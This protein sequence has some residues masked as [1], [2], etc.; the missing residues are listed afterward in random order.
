MY[1]WYCSRDNVSCHVDLSVITNKH[2]LGNKY[3]G[4][5]RV[6]HSVECSTTVVFM[7]QFCGTVITDAFAA[8]PLPRVLAAFV[9]SHLS[10][11]FSEEIDAVL[12]Q[13]SIVVRM[14][15]PL[16]HCQKPALFEFPCRHSTTREGRRY[17]CVSQYPRWPQIKDSN[18]AVL[19]TFWVFGLVA[20]AAS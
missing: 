9:V 15:L 20:V 3:L 7:L 13:E 11:F 1:T 18:A 5:R 12:Q 14:S 19:G 10:L 4:A 17:R 16:L 2:K 8:A 6:L